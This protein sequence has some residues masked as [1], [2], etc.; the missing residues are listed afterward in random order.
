ME[1]WALIISVSVLAIMIGVKMI[2]LWLNR[3]F[4]ITRV[5][6]SMDPLVERQI[7]S[8]RRTL[9]SHKKNVKYVFVYH[10]P[11]YI[12]KLSASAKRHARNKYIVFKEK[13]RGKSEIKN[14]RDTSSIFLRDISEYKNGLRMNE[15]EDN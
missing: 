13:I 3:A 12:N 14:D 4:F 15:V 11:F 6:A 10:V 2:E 7:H 1:I 9:N 5:F 8:S